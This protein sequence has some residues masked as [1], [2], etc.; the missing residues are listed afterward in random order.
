MI[1]VEAPAGDAVDR[2]A[3]GD[4]LDPP[5][6]RGGDIIDRDRGV[7]VEDVGMGVGGVDRI[8][9]PGRRGRLLEGRGIDTALLRLTRKRE[10]QQ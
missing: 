5:L 1:I 3:R 6:G 8:V 10:G 7:A 4:D 9:V 2:V